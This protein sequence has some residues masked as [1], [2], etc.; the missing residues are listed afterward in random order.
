MKVEYLS[1][2][3]NLRILLMGV[4]K[5]MML[6]IKVVAIYVITPSSHFL[7]MLKNL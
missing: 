6:K 5:F 7:R 4:L 3:Q 2:I 1:R